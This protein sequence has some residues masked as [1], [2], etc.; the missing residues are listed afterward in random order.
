MERP[1]SFAVLLAMVILAGCSTP[2]VG[3]PYFARTDSKANVYAGVPQTKVLK[4][5]VLPFPTPSYVVLR[6]S[7]M[8][9]RPSAEV[10]VP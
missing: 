7:R 10:S 2:R 1:S 3:D 9:H 5:A 4:I 8:M 6:I